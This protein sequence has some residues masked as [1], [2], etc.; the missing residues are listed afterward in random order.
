MVVEDRC[1]C[2]CYSCFCSI[3]SCY[4]NAALIQYAHPMVI[5]VSNNMMRWDQVLLLLR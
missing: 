5:I 3:V 4:G 2:L 1:Q